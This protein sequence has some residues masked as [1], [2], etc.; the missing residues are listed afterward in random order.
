[1]LAEVDPRTNRTRY[2]VELGRKAG[3]WDET[4]DGE[5]AR[6]GGSS[7]AWDPMSKMT[8]R[9]YLGEG[10]EAF[11]HYTVCSVRAQ[12]EFSHEGKGCCTRESIFKESFVDGPDGAFH[13]SLFWQK[14]KI[15]LGRVVREL[16]NDAMYE[17][18]KPWAVIYLGPDSSKLLP[19]LVAI[20]EH[21]YVPAKRPTGWCRRGRECQLLRSRAAQCEL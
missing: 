17:S 21:R 15:C 14:P 6:S 19:L 8:V 7:T 9:A 13:S 5:G 11:P 20:L 4:I 3:T 12:D 18:W 2:Q 10:I 16:E 1:M